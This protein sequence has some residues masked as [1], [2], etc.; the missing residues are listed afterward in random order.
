MSI[1]YCNDDELL[2]NDCTSSINKFMISHLILN[3]NKQCIK[4]MR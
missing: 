1:D 4:Y 3:F 2:T